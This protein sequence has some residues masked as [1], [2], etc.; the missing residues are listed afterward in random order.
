MV[1]AVR[2]AFS[3]LVLAG[4]ASASHGPAGTLIIH[5]HE[6][7]C[8]R[9][10]MD[11]DSPYRMPLAD[12]VKSAEDLAW[13]D[14]LPP[15]ARRV[16]RAAGL[17]PLLVALLRVMA[18]DRARSRGEHGL[19]D[20]AL[21]AQHSKPPSQPLTYASDPDELV[22]SAATHGSATATLYQELTLRVLAFDAQLTALAFETQCTRQR[23][24]QLVAA[25]DAQENDRQ[26]SLATG[27][28]VAG[29]GTGIAAGAIDLAGVSDRLPANIAL[30]G[31]VVTAAI[32]AASLLVPERVITLDHH[33]N[34]LRPVYFG[35]DPEHLYPSFVFRMLTARYPGD[36]TTPR[37]HL[38]SDFDAVSRAQVDASTR[39]ESERVL[40]GD[41]GRYPRELLEA[42]VELLHVV[43][44]A[45]HGVA[46]DMELFNRFLVKLLAP[47]R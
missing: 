25:L 13:L 15:E 44:S 21:A 32:G 11:K 45:V 24:A 9:A 10:A 23:A 38:L 4:C 19:S 18:A 26:L 43:E 34:L 8:A 22:A 40:F 17:E 42:R 20:A 28:L 47:P 27:S 16:A 6:A 12:P 41:G 39:A 7:H 1:G 5:E 29:A 46:R 3:L 31:G 2:L 35:Q 36:L 33:R 37:D 14:P 30:L